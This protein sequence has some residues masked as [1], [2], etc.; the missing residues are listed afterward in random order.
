M[1]RVVIEIP[2]AGDIKRNIEYARAC[3]RDSIMRGE[4]PIA[5]HLL[6]T[7]TGILDDNDESERLLGIEI[8]LEWSKFA[9]LVAVYTDLGTTPGMQ[10]G[11]DRAVAE[12]REVVYRT[13]E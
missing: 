3:M 9:Q 12:D 5:S 1:K 11:I 7:Q 10:L 2:Y 8:G 13:I 6:Y 4:A